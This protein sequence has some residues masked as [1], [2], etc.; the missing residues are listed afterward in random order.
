MHWYDKIRPLTPTKDSMQAALR[1]R[2][3]DP[4][5]N[6]VEKL[7]GEGGSLVQARS[8]AHLP[9]TMPARRV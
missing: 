1:A 4:G 5:R 9:P 3:V 6:G 7:K 2:G 8:P